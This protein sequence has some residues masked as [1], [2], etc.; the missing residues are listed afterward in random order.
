[1][2]WDL[3]E[4]FPSLVGSAKLFHMDYQPLPSKRR[5]NSDYFFSGSGNLSG[6]G[7]GSR[8]SNP[9]LFHGASSFSYSH[10]VASILKNKETRNVFFFLLLN[11]SFCCVEFLYGF[12]SNSLGLTSVRWALFPCL[13]DSTVLAMKQKLNF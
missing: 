9:N 3:L 11:I 1:M 2:Y 10:Y 6:G 4:G 12:W 5:S 8:N 13:V 7:K